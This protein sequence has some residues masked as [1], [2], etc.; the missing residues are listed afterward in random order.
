MSTSMGPDGVRQLVPATTAPT[1]I[2]AAVSYSLEVGGA[3][4]RAD[5]GGRGRCDR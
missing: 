5:A 3:R 4:R 1:A 2:V